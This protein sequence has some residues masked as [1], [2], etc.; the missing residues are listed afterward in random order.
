MEVKCPTNSTLKLRSIKLCNFQFHHLNSTA[1]RAIPCHTVLSSCHT[2]L[3]SHRAKWF[4]IAVL[5]RRSCTK[6]KTPILVQCCIKRN[7]EIG[8]C[9]M[10]HC[11]HVLEF[12][13]EL[14]SGFRTSYRTS[15]CIITPIIFFI[16]SIVI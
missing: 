4:V 8:A 5:A 10:L 13:I 12:N 1:P 7:I 11:A 6:L 3:F 16:L 2:I 14:T 15:I 9:C